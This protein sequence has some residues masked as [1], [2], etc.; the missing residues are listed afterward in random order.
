MAIHFRLIDRSDLPALR[1]WFGDEELLR[2]ISY[3]T[4]EWFSPVSGSDAR[5][6]VALDDSGALVGQIQVDFD[7]PEQ[8]YIDFM[9]RPD[10]RGRGL[11]KAVLTAFVSGPSGEFPILEG[12]IE[13]DNVA[14]LSCVQSCGFQLLPDRDEDGFIRAVFMR[15]LKPRQ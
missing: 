15:H 8:G 10:L 1:S 4:D 13:P 11:G 3:P 2:R 5:A 14:S 7:E 9:I 6:W 12:R